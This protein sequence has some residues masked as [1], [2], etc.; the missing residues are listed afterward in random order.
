[1]D[2]SST[3]GLRSAIPHLLGMASSQDVSVAPP[4]SSETQF[5]KKPLP[6]SSSSKP[7][8]LLN[9]REEDTEQRALNLASG[10]PGLLAP[11]LA[12]SLN[13]REPPHL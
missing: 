5:K 13:F 7:S 3:H 12:K 9:F 4:G 11:D 6:A 2:S 10:N 8:C 1:M